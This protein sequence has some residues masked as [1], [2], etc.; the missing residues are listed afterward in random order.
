MS[1]APIT[2]K[3]I[4]GLWKDLPFEKDMMMLGEYFDLEE[5]W[6]T[7]FSRTTLMKKWNQETALG[8][9]DN[10][11]EPKEGSVSGECSTNSSAA[12][13]LE[14]LCPLDLAVISALRLEY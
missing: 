10:I 12:G 7:E 4:S 8:D 9:T 1:P 6:D 2:E 14:D 3:R 13:F 5:E 11:Q